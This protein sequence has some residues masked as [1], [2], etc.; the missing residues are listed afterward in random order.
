[1]KGETPRDSKKE[2]TKHHGLQCRLKPLNIIKLSYI[3]F[4]NISFLRAGWT[5]SISDRW[6]C[7]F[8]NFQWCNVRQNK[9]HVC[10][11]LSKLSLLGLL[12]KIKV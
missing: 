8:Q 11:L 7:G 4:G 12:A 6:R 2:G 3:C 1:M 10:R 9:G 5:M